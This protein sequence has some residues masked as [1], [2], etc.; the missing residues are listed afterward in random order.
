MIQIRF[1]THSR[2]IPYKRFAIRPA[3]GPFLDHTSPEDDFNPRLFF[4]AF[5]SICKEKT[6]IQ[7]LELYYFKHDSDLYIHFHT[8][9]SLLSFYAVNKHLTMIKYIQGLL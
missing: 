9:N 3:R 1:F 8:K 5:R 4:F 2:T 7:I 6:L